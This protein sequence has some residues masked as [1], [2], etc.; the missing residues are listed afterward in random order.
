MT[1]VA[2]MNLAFGIGATFN[3]VSLAVAAMVL[4]V[5]YFPVYRDWLTISNVPAASF[6]RNW[7]RAGLAIKT[8]LLVSALGGAVALWVNLIRP[9]AAMRG[10][11]Y[12]RWTVESVEGNPPSGNG[13]LPLAPKQV[14]TLNKMNVLA[15]R[16][17]DDFR[18]GR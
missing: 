6:G 18:F 13:V 9:L 1:N 10:E 2:A 17:G 4:C 3:A 12:G 16:S 5:L 7:N 14:I 15:V 11:L 8:L